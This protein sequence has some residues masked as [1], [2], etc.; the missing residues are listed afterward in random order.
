MNFGLSLVITISEWESNT[1]G[2]NL[3][4]ECC[5]HKDF[6]VPI[7]LVLGVSTVFMMSWKK[8]QLKP[9]IFSA[10]WALDIGFKISC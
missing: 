4:Y 3:W 2:I 7:I 5:V 1:V 9:L 10:W 8:N 6:I